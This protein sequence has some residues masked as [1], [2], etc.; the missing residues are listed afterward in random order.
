MA[1]RTKNDGEWYV[2]SVS[3]GRERR[4]VTTI[5]DQASRRGVADRVF[6]VVGSTHDGSRSTIPGYVLLRCDMDE[7]VRAFLRSCP[8]VRGIIGDGVRLS[9]VEVSKFLQEPVVATP[10]AFPSG[11]AVVLSSGAFGGQYGVVQELRGD[12]RALVLVNVF[13]RETPIEVNLSALSMA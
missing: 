3:A 4:V 1:E 13:G 6:E 12:S 8:G 7:A 11:S 10:V 5:A 2:L 9:E